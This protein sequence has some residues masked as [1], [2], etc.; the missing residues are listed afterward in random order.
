VVALICTG[1]RHSD[2]VA[3]C[4]LTNSAILR[5]RVFVRKQVHSSKGLYLPSVPRRPRSHL[6]VPL[7]FDEAI[8]DICL[9]K[10]MRSHVARTNVSNGEYAV[11]VC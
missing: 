7:N 3:R 10:N 5:R 6:L 8:F 9:G 1:R 2:S 11:G 4:R